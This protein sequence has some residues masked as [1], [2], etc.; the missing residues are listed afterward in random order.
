MSGSFEGNN[1]TINKNDKIVLEN[2]M[3]LF[4][5]SKLKNTLSIKQSDI[6]NDTKNNLSVQL[7]SKDNNLISTTLQK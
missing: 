3:K 2:N 7:D 5:K 6:I 1:T 4:E